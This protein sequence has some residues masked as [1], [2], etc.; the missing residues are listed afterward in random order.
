MKLKKKKSP[1]TCYFFLVRLS[2]PSPI[3]QMPV[4]HEYENWWQ[5]ICLRERKKYSIVFLLSITVVIAKYEP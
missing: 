5:Q 1:E 4:R 2:D 3:T